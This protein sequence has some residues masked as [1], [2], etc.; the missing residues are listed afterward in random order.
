MAIKYLN[1]VDLTK[2]EL[3][4]AVIQV[5]GTPP[6]TPVEGQIYYDSTDDVIK[7]YNGTAWVSAGGDLTEITTATA[8]QLTITDGQGPIPNIDIVT[9]A[10][11]NAGV[12]LATGDQIY[13]FV[14]TGINARIQNVTDPTG[15]QD[16]ATKN[17]VDTVATGL[18]EYKGGYDASTNTPDL[19]TAT[20]I[21]IDKGDTYTVTADGLFFTE[22][23]RV[24]D[25]IIAEAAIAA[26]TGGTLAD[27]TIVQSNVDLAT[28]AATAGAAVK[29]ISGYNSGDFSVS[30]GFVSLATKT[31]KTSIGGATSIAVT[32]NLV[33]EDVFVQLFDNVTKD[34][35]YA[36][37]VRTNVNTVTID[38]A[39]APAANSIRVLITKI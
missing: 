12:E 1:S 20:N 9:G 5:L 14:T 33:S 4:N 16:V 18:L 15:A 3:Q 21:A 2:N 32:H 34:T 10:V 19:D 38:F 17:Y 31:F 6:G 39:T 37:V 26:N 22:Q 28:A 13:D 30:S 8:D 27:F 25:L 24:G 11:T 36:D 23:V 7:F 29:G 35:V